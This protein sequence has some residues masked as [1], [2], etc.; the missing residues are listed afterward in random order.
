MVFLTTSRAVE[1]RLA[2]REPGSRIGAHAAICRT[3]SIVIGVFPDCLKICSI[4][5]QT[6]VHIRHQ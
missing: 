1:S 3:F 6:N 4:S 2:K 5:C